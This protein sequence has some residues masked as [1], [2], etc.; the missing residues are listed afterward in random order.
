MTIV[1]QFFVNFVDNQWVASVTID[2][3]HEKFF[4]TPNSLRDPGMEL[5]SFLEDVIEEAV[6]D[7]ADEQQYMFFYFATL[8]A[9][10]GHE[11]GTSDLN[12]IIYIARNDEFVMRY[13]QDRENGVVHSIIRK[14][15]DTIEVIPIPMP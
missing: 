6:R 10:V 11:V 15:D 4:M 2:G 3:V 9:C 13:A 7:P 1:D 14:K 5:F 12:E 8:F